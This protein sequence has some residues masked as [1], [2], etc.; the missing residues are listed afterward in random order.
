MSSPSPSGVAEVCACSP[1]PPTSWLDLNLSLVPA[2]MELALCELNKCVSEKSH[3][4]TPKVAA[5]LIEKGELRSAHRGQTIE[6]KERPGAHAE[7]LLLQK[8]KGGQSIAADS[9]LLTTLEPCSPPA[10]RAP[11][12][13]LCLEWIAR[14]GIQ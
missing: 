10:C 4:Q 12:K 2:A 1:L 11:P 3:G 5:V 9:I 8:V 14:S 13:R 6:G 7:Y